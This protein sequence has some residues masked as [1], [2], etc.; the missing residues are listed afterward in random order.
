MGGKCDPR[1]HFHVLA[2]NI[3]FRAFR[4]ANPHLRVVDQAFV[5]AANRQWEALKQ[6]PQAGEHHRA[7]ISDILKFSNCANRLRAAYDEN[8][9]PLI[10][11]ER[12][13]KAFDDIHQFYLEEFDPAAKSERRLPDDQYPIFIAV[14]SKF[15]PASFASG[16]AFIQDFVFGRERGDPF[17]LRLNDLSFCNE[18]GGYEVQRKILEQQGEPAAPWRLTRAANIP[19]KLAVVGAQKARDFITAKTGVAQQHCKIQ[20]E[21]PR[22]QALFDLDTYFYAPEVK[23]DG[24][25][26][27][28]LYF[29]EGQEVP[30]VFGE[31]AGTVRKCLE[32]AVMRILVCP[33]ALTEKIVR[34]DS[35]DPGTNEIVTFALESEMLFDDISARIPEVLRVGTRFA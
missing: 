21:T 27:V 17:G 1:L 16:N 8:T 20:F 12:I 29:F 6:E 24:K 14:L 13:T 4:R 5:L 7:A 23:P 18:G 11:A 28:I 10:K 34:G 30:A 32:G 22:G 2:R 3:D 9:N 26:D 35:R 33:E 15:P 31:T 19:G 25:F